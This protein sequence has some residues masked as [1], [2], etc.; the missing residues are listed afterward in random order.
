MERL[1]V[2]GNPGRSLVVSTTAATKLRRS[3][4]YALKTQGAS[5]SPVP[6]SYVVKSLPVDETPIV[7]CV[8]QAV[9]V[10]QP[11]YQPIQNLTL[12][13]TPTTLRG[14]AVV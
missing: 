7:D 3:F 12:G 9:R 11:K 8:Q 5:G 4:P 13:Y 6:V 1:E 14:Y 10:I 2:G